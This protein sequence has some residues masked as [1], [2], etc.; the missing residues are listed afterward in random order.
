M[1]HIRFLWR[2]ALCGAGE[3]VLANEAHGRSRR[4]IIPIRRFAL[5]EVSR[6]AP[7]TG[8]HEPEIRGV[9]GSW[10]VPQAPRRI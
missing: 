2:P 10:T 8:R 9:V 7:F 1:R 6:S 4:H 5:D 3:P